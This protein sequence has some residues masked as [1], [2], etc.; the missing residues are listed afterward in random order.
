MLAERPNN[1]SLFS[2]REGFSYEKYLEDLSHTQQISAS[3][4][5]NTRAKI[6]SDEALAQKGFYVVSDVGERLEVAHRE[7]TEQTREAIEGVGLEVTSAISG[8]DNT[9]RVSADRVVLALDDVRSEV[10]NLGITVGEKIET[11]ALMLDYRLADVALR[12][13][14]LSSSLEELIQIA[15]TPS[16]TWAME[17]F[18]IARD[19]A[20]RHLYEEALEAIDRAINGYRDQP[21]NKLEHRFHMLAGL[22]LMGQQDHRSHPFVDLEASY[23]HLQNASRYAE[24]VNIEDH[25]QSEA[26][27]GWNRLAASEPDSAIPHL[28]RALTLNKSNGE[29]AFLIAKISSAKGDVDRVKVALSHAILCDPTYAIKAFSDP[30]LDGV[31]KNGRIISACIESASSK[32]RKIWSDRFTDY[33]KINPSIA[34]FIGKE[35]PKPLS[36]RASLFEL[37]H[38]IITDY[39]EKASE[40]LYSEYT[41]ISTERISAIERTVADGKEKLKIAERDKKQKLQ[42]LVSESNTMQ[43]QNENIKTPEVKKSHSA[44]EAGGYLGFAIAVF[45]VFIQLPPDQ[46]FI[47]DAIAMVVVGGIGGIILAVIGGVIGGSIDSGNHGQKQ[48]D[49][50]RANQTDIASRNR[51]VVDRIWSER[52]RIEAESISEI[53]DL[54]TSLEISKQEM[55]EISELHNTIVEEDKKLS[56]LVLSSK[57]Y[58]ELLVATRP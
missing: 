21:G 17:Q 39:L 50:A 3:I 47:L 38:A 18:G 7:A 22:L 20:S 35:V 8:L 19:A 33:S 54:D 24:S 5:R 55:S 37:R 40:G 14:S 57:R 12:L 30:D 36:D 2:S 51:N 49:A 42:A 26:L 29:A 53:A 34:T 58:D 41:K 46:H 10:R 45:L 56:K 32:L 25:S 48:R 31:E 44:S 9:V 27:A 13:G 1:Y 52:K 16:Q 4:D 6:A 28:E 15:K 11:A 23:K 43:E